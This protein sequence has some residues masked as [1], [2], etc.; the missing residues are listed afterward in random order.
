MHARINQVKNA[1]VMCPAAA[2]AACDDDAHV[3][4]SLL[5]VCVVCKLT[6]HHASATA[7]S[8]TLRLTA[9]VH[10]RIQ[11]IQHDVTGNRK[12][13]LSTCSLVATTAPALA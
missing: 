12:S 7:S 9:C 6:H 4:S 13:S 1:S 2:A 5:V 11:Q 10:I 3:Q 8:T